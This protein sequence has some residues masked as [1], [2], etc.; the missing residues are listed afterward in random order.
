MKA[1]TLSCRFFNGLQ[2]DTQT[3]ITEMSGKEKRDVHACTVS[4]FYVKGNI[5]LRAILI[6]K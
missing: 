3:T 1:R 6:L 2:L 5:I 4:K